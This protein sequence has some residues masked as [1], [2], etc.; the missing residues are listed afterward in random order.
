MGINIADKPTGIVVVEWDI[1]GGY[2]EDD[3]EGIPSYEDLGLSETVNIPENIM[4]LYN[5]EA[6]QSG[7][8]QAQQIIT[9]WLSDEYGFCHFGWSFIAYV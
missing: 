6:S 7:H 3:Y 8:P 1:E 5:T 2:D 4:N 9:D